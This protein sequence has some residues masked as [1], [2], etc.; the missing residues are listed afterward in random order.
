[1]HTGDEGALYPLRPA[2]TSPK[3]RGKGVCRTGKQLDKSEFDRILGDNTQS[4][5]EVLPGEVPGR[6]VLI[7]GEGIRNHRFSITQGTVLCV[8][9]NS[10]VLSG[11][12]EN[13][14]C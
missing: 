7:R 4:R 11:S 10:S 8:A 9:R 6:T 3:G 12:E 13:S 5:D 1:M 2:G 14:M